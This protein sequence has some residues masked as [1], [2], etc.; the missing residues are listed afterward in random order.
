MPKVSPNTSSPQYSAGTL[1]R[2]E[3]RPGN[4][5]LADDLKTG[6]AYLQHRLLRHNRLLHGSGVVCGMNVSAANDPSYPWG[7][8]VCPGYAIGPCGDELIIE[9]PELLVVSDF[10][11]MNFQTQGLPGTAYIGIRYAE[12]LVGTVPSPGLEC[13]CDQPAYTPTRIRDSH[14]LAVL[15]TNPQQQR[16]PAD[17]CSTQPA[18]CPDIP[19]SPYLL[20]AWLTLPASVG[21]SITSA[22]IVNI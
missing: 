1:L 16:L 21:T 20:L 14:K 10:L 2:P 8:Y 12:E 7:I 3:Y 5:L 13:D 11:W 19:E 9:Q 6:Q 22:N 15:W 17:I 18:P 4:Y